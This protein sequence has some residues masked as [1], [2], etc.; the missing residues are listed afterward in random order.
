[1]RIVLI[2]VGLCAL[3]AGCERYTEKKSPCIDNTG[4]PI[5]SRTAQT[6]LTINEPAPKT[7]DCVFEDLSGPV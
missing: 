4:K 7:K 1:M 2:L 3:L 6:P 5:V